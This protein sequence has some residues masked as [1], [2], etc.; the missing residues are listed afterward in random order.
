MDYGNA[1]DKNY[2]IPTQFFG[3][4]DRLKDVVYVLITVRGDTDSV[5]HIMYD[6][7]YESR[8]DLTPIQNFTWRLCPRNLTFRCLAPMRYGRVAKRLPGCRHVRH[9]SMTLADWGVGEDLAIVS[10]QIFYKFSGKER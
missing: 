7:D 1:I 5:I 2:T 9:F 6:T 10:I 3:T 8:V 4:Y